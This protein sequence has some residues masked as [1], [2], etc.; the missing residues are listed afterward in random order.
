M[1][2]F[3]HR[4]SFFKNRNATYADEGNII[5]GNKTS[6]VPDDLRMFLSSGKQLVYDASQCEAGMIKL[7]KLQNL[8]LQNMKVSTKKVKSISEQDDPNKNKSGSYVIPAISLIYECRTYDPLFLLVWLPREKMYGSL[9][10]EGM[11]ELL[12]F[13][14][15]TWADIANNFPLYI[16]AQWRSDY[17]EVAVDF[18]PWMKYRFEQ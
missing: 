4:N 14:N 5:G 12:V 10:G 15:T 7:K 9:G 1:F 6:D 17:N 8:Q 11:N 13:P 18:N 2:D 3:F 16:N